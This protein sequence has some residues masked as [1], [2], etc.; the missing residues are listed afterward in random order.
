M[1]IEFLIKKYLKI[2]IYSF[3]EK[4]YQALLRTLEK[5]IKDE[6]KFCHQ[7]IYNE[8]GNTKEELSTFVQSHEDLR[9][10]VIG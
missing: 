9:L 1:E 3:R 8:R 6:K 2:I 4:K 7:L 10:G 5:Y